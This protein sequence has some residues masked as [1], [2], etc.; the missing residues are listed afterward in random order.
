MI[1][2]QD[3]DIPTAETVL[4]T[5]DERYLLASALLQPAPPNSAGAAISI[6]WLH[7]YVLAAPADLQVWYQRFMLAISIASAFADFLARDLGLPTSDE[8]PA[9]AGILLHAAEPLSK[10]VATAG[11]SPLPDTA[12]ASQFL[13]YSIADPSGQSP[14]ELTRH[15]LIELC[16]DTLHLRDFDRAM[17]AIDA[18]PTSAD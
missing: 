4:I 14:D 6:F 16:R 3:P 8:R 7:L 2:W 9:A 17:D 18:S 11:L 15:L 10:L 5:T 1:R 12:P 13:G